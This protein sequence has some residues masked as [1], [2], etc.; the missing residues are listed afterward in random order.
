VRTSLHRF[1]LVAAV[2]ALSL[3]TLGA[4]PASA[5]DDIAIVAVFVGTAHI[6]CFGCG[7]S[8][9]TADLQGQDPSVTAE[10]ETDDLALEGAVATYT[11]FE[12][13]GA[14]CVISGSANGTTTGELATVNFSWTRVGAV[15]VI[16]TT[17]EINGAGVAAFVVTSPIG[18]PCGGPVDA[19]V[20][21]TVAGLAGA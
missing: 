4:A 5:D 1:G 18:N 16:T 7:V 2:A 10:V 11:V 3:G 17:G 14:T 21:G 8:N 15:A 19:T 20:V 9:G 6:N 12:P 13:T